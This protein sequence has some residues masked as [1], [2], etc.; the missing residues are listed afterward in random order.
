MKCMGAPENRRLLNS[1]ILDYFPNCKG[2]MEI[3]GSIFSPGRPFGISRMTALHSKKMRS[4]FF[5]YSS[6]TPAASQVS[7]VS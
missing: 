7:R 2:G 3:T 1:M 4:I 6:C 5:D